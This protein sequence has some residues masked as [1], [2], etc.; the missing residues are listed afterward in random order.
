MSVA[1]I[2]HTATRLLR[3]E[4]FMPFAYNDATRKRVSC[5][6]D[7]NLTWLIGL[8]L[9]TAGSMELAQ[10]VVCHL[11]AEL[12]QKLTKFWWYPAL[13]DAR[14]SVVLDVG[15]NAGASGLLH[16]PKMLA[17]IGAKDWPTAQAELLDSDAARELK[18]RY[19]ALAKILLTGVIA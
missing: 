14:L 5:K 9:E 16:F 13:D 17:A 4:E 6:P 11:L 3:E 1:A 19:D 12:D 8:N 15:F 18:D 7:G 2:A 10:V